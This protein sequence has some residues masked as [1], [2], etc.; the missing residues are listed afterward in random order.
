MVNMQ[1]ILSRKWLE[2]IDQDSPKMFSFW[3]GDNQKPKKAYS[4]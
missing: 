1:Q 2:G 3:L 4:R